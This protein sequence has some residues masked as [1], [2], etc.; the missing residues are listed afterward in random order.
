MILL[1]DNYDSFVYNLAQYIG[2][3]G[4]EPV[5]HR[6]DAISIDQIESLSPS[7]IIVSP[8]PCT[9]LEAGISN[10]VVRRFSGSIPILGVCLGHQCI[11]HVN[12]GVIGRASPPMHGKTSEVHHDGRTIF[13]GLPDP[14]IGGRYHSLIVEADSFSDSLEVSAWTDDGAIMG[15][16][17]REY[18]VEGIQF[19]PES[20]LTGVGHDVLRK[21]LSFSA[22]LWSRL[23]S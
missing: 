8:G 19:H 14:F 16:R 20:I 18:V 11:G 4:W 6:N 1:I 23:S 17:H 15:L 21:F 2:E 13:S 9:P 7:H 3:L 5:V 22:P 12:G 10:D